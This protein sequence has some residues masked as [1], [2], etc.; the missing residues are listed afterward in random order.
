MRT[1]LA[2]SV[3]FLSLLLCSCSPDGARDQTRDGDLDWAPEAA[4]HPPGSAARS[5]TYDTLTIGYWADE[6]LF[7]PYWGSLMFEPLFKKAS[8]GE[9]VGALVTRWEPSEDFRTWTYT[10]HS[11]VR[12]HDGVPLTAHDVKFT[13]DLSAHPEVLNR[14]APGAR[15]VRVLNDTTFQITFAARETP[16]LNWKVFP[17]HLLEDLDPATYWEWD[18]WSEP[19]GSGPYRY[20]RHVDDQ[21]MEVEANPDYYRG[22]PAIEEVVFRFGGVALVELQAG[23]IDATG[24]PASFSDAKVLS[25]NPDFRVYSQPNLN[26]SIALYW[27][28]RNP[29]F[30]D[31][32]VRRALTM[33]IDRHELLQVMN[34][35]GETPIVDAVLP[36]DP[37][38]FD[39][40]EGLP[41]DREEARRLLE[42]AGWRDDDG[43]GI[44][45]RGSQE[46]R[47]TAVASGAR[48]DWNT[49]DHAVYVQA[50]LGEVGVRMEI[51]TVDGYRMVKNAIESGEADAAVH[52]FHFGNLL[53]VISEDSYIGYDDPELRNLIQ[54]ADAAWDPEER[55][56]LFRE[57]LPLF[58]ERLPVTVLVPMVAASI[59]H[60]KVKGLR[61][62][63]QID[64]VGRVQ[65]LWI[66]QNPDSQ[67][68][69]RQ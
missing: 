7:G 16:T 61:S 48:G 13:M 12:W 50:K 26:S 53:D 63:D 28:H 27:N 39:P 44:R 31:V 54:T 23:N 15:T 4:S 52:R 67:V 20:V 43:D 2:L 17:R 25:R 6:T 8:A 55:R 3:L 57:A 18:F 29:L 9:W 58:R 30:K 65:E 41:Y 36:F 35:P 19:V 42:N 38:G 21:M 40:G 66:E 68:G 22:P 33:A 24:P 5:E 69:G 45:Q 37:G 1:S 46:F 62:P 11:G 51:R 32:A 60:R 47:F 34:I 59:A 49:L 10:I 14:T 64:P 56:R